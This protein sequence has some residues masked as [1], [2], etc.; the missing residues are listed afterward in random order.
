VGTGPLGARP[1]ETVSV[2]LKVSNLGEHQ[3][4]AIQTLLEYDDALLGDPKGVTSSTSGPWSNGMPTGPDYDGNKIDYGIQIPGSTNAEVEVAVFTFTAGSTEGT[5]YVRF[6]PDAPEQGRYTKLNAVPGN[7][8]IL[9]AKWDAGQIVIDGTDPEVEV[10][11]PSGG[12]SLLGG[13]P[14]DIEWWCDEANLDT[15][16]L[17]YSADGGATWTTIQ[18]LAA[19]SEYAVDGWYPW[20]VPAVNSDRCLVKVIATDKAGNVGE[21]VSDDFF[22][23]S[24]PV[25]T[26]RSYDSSSFVS[27]YF[28]GL[29][30]VVDPAPAG[31]TEFSRG[32]VAGSAVTL[33]APAIHGGQSF[34]HWKLDDIDQEPGVAELSVT[35]DGDHTAVAVY[36]RDRLCID[37]QVFQ[38][39]SSLL[40]PTGPAPRTLGILRIDMPGNPESDQ[41]AITIGDGK[42]FRFVTD[43]CGNVDAFPDG[44]APDWH[45]AAEWAGKRI[46]GLTPGTTYSFQAK[47]RADPGAPETELIDVGSYSTNADRDVDR[48]GAVMEADLIFVRDAV[49]SGA[50]IGQGGKAWATD[51]NDTRTTTVLDLILIRNR[52]LGVD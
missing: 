34:S 2:K 52:I 6:R 24:S 10:W 30:I 47:T 22:S 17:Q 46:R 31:V 13:E 35:M 20:D 9:P 50:E 41:V 51:V 36:H 23:I 19:D 16:T 32:Y 45:T 8:D 40:N 27:D 39:G 14:F 25:L 18:T 4:N 3:I 11:S 28:T 37:M 44:A 15:I 26:V 21:D 5:A 1:G 12:E 38:H 43:A 29:P 48:S 33:T 49:L 42:W 7:T